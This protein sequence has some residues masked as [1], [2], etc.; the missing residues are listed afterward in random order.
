VYLKWAHV[1]GCVEVEEFATL[2]DAVLAAEYASDAGT[3]S[4]SCIEGPDGT[5]SADSYRVIVDAEREAQR[6]RW[7]A[8]EPDKFRVSVFPPD[9]VTKREKWTVLDSFV[10][11]REARALFDEMVLVVGADRVRFEEL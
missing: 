6:A 7:K 11:E 5:V 4:L 3:E 10:G 2:E 9:G 1:Y 8:A